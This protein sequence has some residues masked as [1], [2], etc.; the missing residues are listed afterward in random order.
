M[1][2]PKS[3]GGRKEGREERREERREGEREGKNGKNIHARLLLNSG[4]IPS[5]KLP[6]F[7]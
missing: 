6:R 4:N 5:E 7:V 1:R 3:E 2:Q